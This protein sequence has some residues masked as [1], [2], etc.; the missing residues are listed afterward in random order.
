[1]PKQVWLRINVQ[2]GTELLAELCEAGC[3]YN[4]NGYVK[5]MRESRADEAISH[6]RSRGHEVERTTPPEQRRL[7]GWTKFA[8]GSS[9][10]SPRRLFG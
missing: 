7:T 9:I 8:V 6:L 10:D 2:P 4:G 3:F 1:M 5:V